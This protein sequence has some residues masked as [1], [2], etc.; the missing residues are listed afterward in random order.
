[1]FL[2]N[3]KMSIFVILRITW[4]F[5]TPDAWWRFRFSA[6]P[7]RPLWASKRSCFSL[8]FL[9]EQSSAFSIS[10]PLPAAVPASLFG[11][12]PFFSPSLLIFLSPSKSSFYSS[13]SSCSS[14]LLSCCCFFLPSFSLGQKNNK[15][16]HMLL[17]LFI[18]V[19]FKAI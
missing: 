7:L 17:F 6:L 3:T 8:S 14:T 5:W 18:F 16:L 13:T 10:S 15:R 9:S 19:K 11:L 12:C 1:M 4:T 2:K